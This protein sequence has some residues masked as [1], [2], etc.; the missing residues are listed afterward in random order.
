VVSGGRVSRDERLVVGRGVDAERLVVSQGDLDRKS[1]LD[2]AELFEFLGR[3]EGC[4][5]DSR[6]FEQKSPSVGVQADV[7]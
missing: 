1:V 3:L 2:G 7:Q 6:V 4:G 5:R